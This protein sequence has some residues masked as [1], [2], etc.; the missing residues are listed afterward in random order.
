MAEVGNIEEERQGQGPI[1]DLV[2]KITNKESN[3]DIDVQEF[4]GKLLGRSFKVMGKMNI[5]L[6][7][8]KT[9]K[10]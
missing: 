1:L 5:T 6:G 7:T 2:D 4:G 10:E 8:L 3:I 9:P